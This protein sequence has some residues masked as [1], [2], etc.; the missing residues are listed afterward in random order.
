M[1]LGMLSD[2]RAIA[3]APLIAL[4]H[5][6]Q[7]SPGERLRRGVL[8]SIALGLAFVV[9]F[10]AYQAMKQAFVIR[11]PP[12]EQWGVRALKAQLDGI[13]G[14]L[15][16]ALRAGWLPPL[17]LA[18]AWVAR[19]RWWELAAF[20]GATLFALIPGCLVFTISRTGAMAFPALL[21]A[22]VELHR[23]DPPQ[24][25]E[26]LRSSLRLNVFTPQ[27]QVVAKVFSL[28]RPLPLRFVHAMA[29]WV[30]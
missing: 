2:E 28:Y 7:D 21:I 20:T 5:A 29:Q 3:A 26:T 9:W 27:Y 17:V 14:G 15:F 6:L 8:R 18:A 22:L 1:F 30:L 4:W 13:P 23:L 25:R 16:Y 24:F 12:A 11:M 19:R 10:A